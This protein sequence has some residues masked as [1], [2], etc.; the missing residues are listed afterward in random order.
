LPRVGTAAV[1]A[2]RF[3][4]SSSARA[5]AVLALLRR[6]GFSDAHIARM[7][8]VEPRLLCLDSDTIIR[9]E[10][11]F[12]A[13]LGI[14]PDAISRTSVLY[15]SLD[16]HI[17]PRFE[18]LRAVLGSDA[19]IRTA[20]S[21]NPYLLTYDSVIK[22]RAAVDTLSPHGLRESDISKPLTVDPRENCKF[23]TPNIALRNFAIPNIDFAEI[24]LEM[25][26]SCKPCQ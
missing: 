10:L 26:S 3:R 14:Q 6:H 5:D 25:L 24:D 23:G 1:A 19:N 13:A 18:F 16:K 21:S 22:L 4:I 2:H 8:R 20:V 9:P 7:L 11:D 12:L 17:A 15:C